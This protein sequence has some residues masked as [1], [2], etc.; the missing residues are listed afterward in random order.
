LAG[1][2][3]MVIVT[4]AIDFREIELAFVEVEVIRQIVVGLTVYISVLYTIISTNNIPSYP[5]P[6]R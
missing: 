1:E 6:D 2:G 3:C 4:N 5:I